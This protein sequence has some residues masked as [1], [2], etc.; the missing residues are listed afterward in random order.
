[1]GRWDAVQEVVGSILTCSAPGS[2]PTLHGIIPAELHFKPH[3]GHLNQNFLLPAFRCDR[4]F[5]CSQVSPL[6]LTLALHRRPWEL[7]NGLFLCGHLPA[8]IYGC[9]M[10]GGL[11]QQGKLSRSMRCSQSRLC[12]PNLKSREVKMPFCHWDSI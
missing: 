3:M 7:V 4:L 11:G 10:E 8:A 1:M 9:R 2:P 5:F 12:A 6:L